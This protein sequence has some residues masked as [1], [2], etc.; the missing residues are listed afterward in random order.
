MCVKLDCTWRCYQL[1]ADPVDIVEFV[2][3]PCKMYRE[4][5]NFPVV[6]TLLGFTPSFPDR[7]DDAPSSAGRDGPRIPNEAQQSVTTEWWRLPRLEHLSV[8]ATISRSFLVLGWFTALLFSSRVNGSQLIGGSRPEQRQHH[9]E[10][11]GW[12]GPHDTTPQSRQPIGPSSPIPPSVSCH[13][14][15]SL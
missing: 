8:N 5:G 4:E 11:H 2:P 1:L 14:P 6:V 7:N 15:R 9:Q 12:A 10:T 3:G 13:Q